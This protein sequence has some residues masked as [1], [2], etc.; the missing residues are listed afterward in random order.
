MR[1]DKGKVLARLVF[2]FEVWPAQWLDLTLPSK[3]EK[4]RFK[5]VTNG[6]KKI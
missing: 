5:S 2:L 4:F 1:I 3:L 6:E